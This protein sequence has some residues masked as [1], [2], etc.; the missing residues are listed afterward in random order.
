M[1]SKTAIT[2]EVDG[3]YIPISANHDR[4]ASELYSA[5]IVIG[6]FVTLVDLAI[7]SGFWAYTILPIVAGIAGHV[8]RYLCHDAWRQKAVSTEDIGDVR[9][10]LALVNRHEIQLS[11]LPSPADK[12]SN[13]ELADWADKVNKEL[14]VHYRNLLSQEVDALSCKV[15]LENK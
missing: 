12:L 14:G 11:K 13:G 5:L 8:W 7:S 2:H 9:R 3:Q 10:F 1:Q 6:C 4:P 15:S